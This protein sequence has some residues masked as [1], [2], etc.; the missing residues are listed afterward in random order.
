M[1]IIA[2]FTLLCIIQK[3]N[4]PFVLS[5]APIKIHIQHTIS[6]PHF[7]QNFYWCESRET[8]PFSVQGSSPLARQTC[9]PSG[10]RKLAQCQGFYTHPSCSIYVEYEF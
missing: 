6:I 7:G 9:T 4:W 10:E 5:K 8:Q 2:Y 1:C 3:E